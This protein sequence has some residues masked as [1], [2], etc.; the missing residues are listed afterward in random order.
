MVIKAK[1]A[2]KRTGTRTTE[3]DRQKIIKLMAE[4]PERGGIQ[5]VV[6][7]TGFTV[8][9][10]NNVLKR[11]GLKGKGIV[12]VSSTRRTTYET[13]LE[14]RSLMQEISQKREELKALVQKFLD[15]N[16]K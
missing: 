9:T 7:A 15:F 11:A 14:S 16:I 10:I 6:K 4:H 13:S 12:S 3:E 8:G 2:S 5:E 1:L